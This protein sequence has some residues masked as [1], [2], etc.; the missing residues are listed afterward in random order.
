[1]L[2]TKKYPVLDRLRDDLS[3]KQEQRSW[4]LNH[5][6]SAERIEQVLPAIEATLSVL[7]NYPGYA[8]SASYFLGAGTWDEYQ[9]HWWTLKVASYLA[10][11]GLLREMETTLPN[12]RVP[13]MVGEIFLEGQPSPFYVEAKSW[14]FNRA[15]EVII[16]S[17]EPP[18]DKRIER[19]KGKLLKQ[20][21]EDSF[22]VWAWDKM[23]DV[24]SGSHTLGSD[25]PKLGI[26]ESQV[27]SEVCGAVP[28][29]S[30]LPQS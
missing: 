7:A 3:N 11:K 17:S 21:P 25:G 8:T 29:L 9:E 20:L 22:G 14:R 30:A 19:M 2:D 16:P 15:P 12:G 26:E 13:D 4:L 27:I 24:I 10:G 23:R 18:L 1:M 5:E 28:Q 6:H